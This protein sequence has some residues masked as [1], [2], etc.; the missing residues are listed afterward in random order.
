MTGSLHQPTHCVIAIIHVLV[1]RSSRFFF[2]FIVNQSLKFSIG[3][4]RNSSKSIFKEFL[5]GVSAVNAKQQ[6]WLRRRRRIES[7]TKKHLKMGEEERFV[8]ISFLASFPSFHHQSIISR[9]GSLI[10]L[11]FRLASISLLQHV[12]QMCQPGT[13][14]NTFAEALLSFYREYLRNEKPA[15][16]PLSRRTVSRL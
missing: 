10:L 8:F 11:Q 15:T 6:N 16:A 2:G 12:R 3:C 13:V 1:S 5:F 9:N 14:K 4:E 7:Q